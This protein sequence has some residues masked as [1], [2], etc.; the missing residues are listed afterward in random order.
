MRKANIEQGSPLWLK[1]RCGRITSSRIADVIAKPKTKRTEE[2]AC[3]RDYRSDLLCE[4]L[5]NYAADHYVSPPM[6]WGI[7]HE[8]AAREAY[9]VA[10]DI[11]EEV[12][13]VY[14]P[15]FD[16][17]GASP[18]GL[19][20]DDGAIEIKCPTTSVHLMYRANDVI[21]DAYIPQMMW[22]MACTEARWCDFISFDPRLPLNLRFF[23]KR[24]ERDEAFIRHMEFEVIKFD[25]EINET[26]SRLGAPSWEPRVTNLLREGVTRIGAHDV[27]NDLADFLE[28]IEV[29]P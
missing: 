19:V 1:I 10:F 21:P 12:G 29:V 2:L 16:F 18:D 25:A 13:F 26:I 5:T 22:V 24:L 9:E 8:S 14:H 4:R 27:P 23:V 6:Q 20:G 15:A 7:D 28:D 17:A 11:V 3:K